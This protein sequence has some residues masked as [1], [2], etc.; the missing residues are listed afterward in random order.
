MPL[1]E[2]DCKECR[3]KFTKVLSFRDI[4]VDGTLNGPVNE[5]LTR[6]CTV[7]GQPTKRVI[8]SVPLEAHL[9]GDP[10]GYYKPSP[11]KRHSYKL[12]SKDGNKDSMG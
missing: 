9:Y 11:T 8:F 7:C 4:T 1:L 2:F 12:A 6:D 10:D 3:N 5:A